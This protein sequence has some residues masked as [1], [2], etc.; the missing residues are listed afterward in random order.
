MSA[1]SEMS[2]PGGGK[3]WTVDNAGN[4]VCPRCKR[5][6]STIGGKGRTVQNLPRVPEHSRPKSRK[7]QRPRD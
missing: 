6:L 1:A 4:P 5:A 3:A 7:V 2:C